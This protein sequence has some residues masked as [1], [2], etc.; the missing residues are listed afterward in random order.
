MPVIDANVI[1]HGRAG[2]EFSK[3]F[4]TPSVLEEMKSSEASLKADIMELEIEIP[5]RNTVNKV[6]EKAREIGANTSET[7]EELLA[8]ALTLDKKLVTD[9]KDLQNLGLHMGAEIDG[10]M[11]DRIEE[12]LEWKT[13]CSNCG[14][15][16]SSPPCPRCGE[17]QT[18]RKLD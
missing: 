7:D 17:T 10:F 16:I 2:E 6:K 18:Q 12:K 1:I 9:D 5:D 8:L 15:E 11:D 14:T 13:V 4:T 3:A